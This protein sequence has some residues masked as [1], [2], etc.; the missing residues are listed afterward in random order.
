LTKNTVA[1]YYDMFRN[2]ISASMD[3]EECQIGSE[4][5]KVEIEESKMRK[6][7]YN[8]GHRVEGLWVIGGVE[9]TPD[10][11]DFFVAVEN[12]NVETMR[13][14]LTRHVKEGSI[15]Y[16]DMWRGYNWIDHSDTMA[17]KTGSMFAT[18]VFIGS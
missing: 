9:R 4:G 1:S 18:F 5:I 13:E 15:I 8:R 2:L 16:T 12:R 10:R 17:S 7:I 14:V 3:V 6:R 11:Q